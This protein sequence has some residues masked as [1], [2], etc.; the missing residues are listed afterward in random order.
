MSRR[1]I[2][3]IDYNILNSTG[4]IIHLE[5]QQQEDLTEHLSN[6]NLD[7]SS[8]ADNN[9]EL[10][11]DIKV[12]IE[13]IKNTIDEDP[14]Q[15]C[16]PS[17]V[18]G[19][20]KHL[21]EQRSI[22]RRKGLELGSEDK[23]TEIIQL[24]ITNTVASIKDYIKEAKEYKGKLTFVQSK[25][26]MESSICRERS[27]T[28]ALED[29]E[30]N[31]EQL[32]SD[33]QLHLS[34]TSDVQLMQLKNEN[35]SISKRFH[36][37]SEKYESILQSPITNAGTLMA[38]KDFGNRYVKLDSMKHNF[39][40]AVN[41][42]VSKRK[43]G[44]DLHYNKSHLNIILE[45]FRGYESLVD[46]YKFRDI[47]EKLCLQSTPTEFLPD[48]LKNNLLAEPAS[49]L[50]RSINNIHEIWQKLKSAY[51]D[52]KIMLS[53][54]LRTLSKS[55]LKLRDPEKLI[56]AISTFTNILCELIL[57]ANKP[58]IEADLYYGDALSKIYQ[59]L[60]DRRLTR[61]LSSISEEEPNEKETWQKILKFLE[62]E[63]KLQQQK[64]IIN[65]SRSDNRDPSSKSSN[66]K[67]KKGSYFSPN[68][69]EPHCHICGES[70]GSSE[71]TAT[72]GPGGL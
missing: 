52:T 20:I 69:N 26:S 42:E 2:K 63:E 47:F 5:E 9:S 37:T 34:T 51:G 36:K 43:L 23:D 59:Q 1:N 16:M 39:V 49:T 65:N 64:L 14:V 8:M 68:L 22:L 55:D 62:K 38:I 15:G 45:K 7:D 27:V 61:F 32:E 35:A 71:H 72:F 67:G 31:I 46:Y 66:N 41:D 60:G 30:R 6:L 58:G 19:T 50:V 21:E 18:D 24:S 11:I 13:G 57:L 44:K 4:A 17:E 29:M 10:V 25:Q 40:K 53:R 28:F 12:L 54:K 70:A 33:F 56:Y 3:R 48:L